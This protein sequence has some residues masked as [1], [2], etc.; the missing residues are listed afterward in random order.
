MHA[1]FANA[2]EMSDID[3]EFDKPAT[4]LFIN[5]DRERIYEVVSNLL[6][7]A[8]SSTRRNGKI[9]VSIQ[10]VK[11]TTNNEA[12][13]DEN[14]YDKMCIVVSIKDNGIGID[15]EIL[16]RL[17]TKFA[18]KSELGLGLGLYISKSIILAHGGKIWGENNEDGNGAK[19][20][21]SLEKA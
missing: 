10:V 11:C 13:E 5:A 3:I 18:S 16:P 14:N 20:A 7:N 9:T 12:R 17:F 21:F 6:N 8:I 4:P 15:P 1:Q 2:K 19:F